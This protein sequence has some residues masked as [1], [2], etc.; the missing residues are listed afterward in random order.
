MDVQNSYEPMK[1]GEG[2]WRTLLHNSS[3]VAAHQVA[4]AG[5]GSHLQPT[6]VNNYGSC[7]VAGEPTAGVR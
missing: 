4:G 1:K 7:Q 5:K 2:K 6:N 3:T